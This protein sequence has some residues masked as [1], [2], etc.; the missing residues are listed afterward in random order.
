M[1]SSQKNNADIIINTL[2]SYGIN[3]DF[4]ISAILGVVMKETQLTPK[5]ENLSYSAKRIT[6]VWPRIPFEKAKQLEKNP[7]A[8]GNFVYG[9][10]FG[11][12]MNEGYL[13]RGRGFN[14]LT[15]K[16]NYKTYGLLINENLVNNPDKANEV[17]TAAKILYWYMKRNAD[18]YNINLNNLNVDN[19]YNIIYS[20][21]AGK[22]PNTSGIVLQNTDTTGGYLLGKT[23]Y[24]SFLNYTPEKKKNN[25]SLYIFAVGLIALIFYKK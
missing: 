18:R 23:Y 2:K 16:D 4:T 12:G 9:G 15:F 13:Y 22:N 8:L 3:N 19:A 10:R 20:F 5:S 7:V 21:N 24:S 25:L 11:N 14:Q 1:T 17:Q 6:E